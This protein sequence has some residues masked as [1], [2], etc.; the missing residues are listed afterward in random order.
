MRLTS[1]VVAAAVI[2][3][4]PGA[5]GV[6]IHERGIEIATAGPQRLAPDATLLAGAAPFRVI[7]RA[8][9]SD[10]TRAIAEGGLSDLRL[11]SSR[12][13]RVVPYL[14][15]YPPI[16]E[17]QWRRAVVQLQAPTEKTSGFE[18]DLLSPQTID[19]VRLDGLPRPFLKRALVEASGDREH[20]TMV[21]GEG[22]MFDLPD[23]QLQQT[24]VSFAPGTYRYVRVTWDDRNSGRVPPPAAVWARLASAHATPAP[25]LVPVQLEKRPSEPQRTRYHLTLPGARLPIV[26]L[27]L[28]V[29]GT[30]VFRRAA[31]TEARL[32]AWQAEPVTIGRSALVREGTAGVLRLPIQQPSQREIDLLDRGR[33]QRAA[34][35]PIDHRG[36]RRA[37]VD[38]LRGGWTGDGAVRRHQPCRARVRPRG[39]ACVDRHRA[40]TRGALGLGVRGGSVALGV[41]LDLGRPAGGRRAARDLDVQV[42]ARDRRGRSRARRRSARRRGARPQRGPAGT[43]R[44]S[45]GRGPDPIGRSPGSS[46]TARSRCRWH[47]RPRKNR[48]AP[49]S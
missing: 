5:T 43:L 1:L 24:S 47:S 48:P 29:G 16:D 3:Q 19:A 21:V 37:A 49:W 4:A 30:Y 23:Q 34:R 11:V 45:A 44:G 22:T 7:P 39:R 13:G 15:V 26:A 10:S 36:A 14:L 17:P 27:R 46:S 42:L 8:S 40:R 2:A 12:D 38:L 18:A 28:D 41:S 25:S 20:W 35:R 31:V 6:P 9:S 33:G 32:T